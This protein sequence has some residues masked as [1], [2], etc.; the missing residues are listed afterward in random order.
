MAKYEIGDEVTLKGRLTGGRDQAGA[1]H[2]ELC[3]GGDTTAILPAHVWAFPDAFL[4]HTPKP[5]EL[6]VGDAVGLEGAP[7]NF[8]WQ[9]LAVHDEWAWLVSENAGAYCSARKTQIVQ[10]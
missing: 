1:L 7:E 2:I 10:R 4:T 6:K 8:R 5:R 3:V 9:V